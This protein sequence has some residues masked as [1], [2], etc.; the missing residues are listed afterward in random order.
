MAPRLFQRH[1]PKGAK[2]F[3]PLFSKSG[4]LSFFLASR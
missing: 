4:D 1:S 2:V 3:A